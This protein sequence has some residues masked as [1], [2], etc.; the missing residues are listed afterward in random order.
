MSSAFFAIVGVG[1]QPEKDEA[2]AP[3]IAATKTRPKG[4]NRLGQFPAS[5]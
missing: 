4:K 1:N 5:R 2:Q 3:P